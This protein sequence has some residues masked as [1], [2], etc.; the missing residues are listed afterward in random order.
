MLH[1]VVLGGDAVEAAAKP[2]TS[3]AFARH[4]A[5]VAEA[6]SWK[7]RWTA[8]AN[9]LKSLII[10]YKDAQAMLAA[11]QQRELEQAAADARRREE[12]EARKAMRNGDMAAAQAAMTRAAEVVTPV[13]MSGTPV[14]ENSSDR[15]PWEVTVTDMEALVKAIAAGIVPISAIKEFDMG[16]LKREAAKR[17]GLNWPG[18]SARQTTQLSV[19]R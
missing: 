11:R 5:L 18:V 8:M 13:V 10:R 12:E 15:R 19:R 16:F 14:L 7:A 6:N 17:G 1:Q 3:E 2:V 4:K 9:G